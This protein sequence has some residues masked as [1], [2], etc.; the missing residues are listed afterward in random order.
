[1]PILFELSKYL[2]GLLV[3]LSKSCF[4][5]MCLYGG[6]EN[7]DSIFYIYSFNVPSLSKQQTPNT[8]FLN[9]ERVALFQNVQFLNR[10]CIM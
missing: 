5:V 1:M 4:H 7:A 6:P 2:H 10:K 8:K 9:I 3:M